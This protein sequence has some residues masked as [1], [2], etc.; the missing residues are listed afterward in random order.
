M[1]FITDKKADELG[2]LQGLDPEARGQAIADA[3]QIYGYVRRSE[4][5]QAKAVSE[6]S[7]RKWAEKNDIG[8]DRA[9]RALGVLRE[10]GRLVPLPG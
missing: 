6:T 4:A 3:D 8:P 9:N 7:I 2:A 10:L 5:Q 1:H